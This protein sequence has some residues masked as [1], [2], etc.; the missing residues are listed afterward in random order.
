MAEDIIIQWLGLI[1]SI[2]VLI[3]TGFWAYARFVLERNALPSVQPELVCNVPGIQDNKK[4]IEILLH[5]KNIGSST[6]VV[7][8]IY[9]DLLYITN[10]DQQLR[11]FG[12]PDPKIEKIDPKDLDKFGILDFPHTLRKELGTIELKEESVKPTQNKGTDTKGKDKTKPRGLPQSKGKV[13]FVQPGVDQIF[14]FVT[15]LPTTASYLLVHAEFRYIQNRN[16]G[17]RLLLYITKK[18]GL[19]Q[20]TLEEVEY[21]HTLERVFNITGCHDNSV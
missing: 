5:L 3:V 1:L 9:V 8:K 17:R 21:P 2:V 19:I 16:L 6:L 18:L 14:T 12:E 7:K 10:N 20:F 4:I 11:L 13:F 15:G